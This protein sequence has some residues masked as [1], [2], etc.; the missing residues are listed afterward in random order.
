MFETYLTLIVSFM[1][2]NS[3]FALFV[4][5]QITLK[6]TSPAVE[7]CRPRIICD[8]QIL[9]KNALVLFN[10]VKYPFDASI[11]NKLS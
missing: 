9:P 1:Y 2:F 10:D 8:K 3:L 4:I 6:M 11:W 7:T 5:L